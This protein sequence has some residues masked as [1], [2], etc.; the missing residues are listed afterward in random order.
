MQ[1]FFQ[2]F[3]SAGGHFQKHRG[4]RMGA[5]LSYYAVFSIA[6]LGILIIALVGSVFG[7]QLVEQ[8][9]ITQVERF[10][11]G[12]SGEFVQS[13]ITGVT[14][15]SLSTIGTV[16][17]IAT[18]IF[19]VVS[20]MSVLDSSLDELWET[21]TVRT[22]Q[23][24]SFWRHLKM[25]IKNRLPAFAMLPIIA[26]LFLFFV[27]T[28]VS[29]VLFSEQ[30]KGFGD[31]LR[32]VEPVAL[33]VL[34]TVF[35]A[36]VYKILPGRSLPLRELLIGGVVTSTLF[37]IGRLIIGYYISSF[38]HTT[39]YGAA[40]SLVAILIWIYYS[41]QV[42]FFGASFTYIYSKKRGVLSK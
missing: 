10:I 1:T 34:G 42:F 39:V 8:S 15:Q 6:P 25:M 2:V 38:A 4:A 7:T 18:I 36:L 29:L 17:S 22:A 21:K 35:F 9:V 12:G 27:A 33:F 14:S 19:G 11:G 37:V 32:F 3:K 20:L 40:G 41:S 5:A 24:E 13:L 26:I 31:T 23:K 28:S 30:L 16:L